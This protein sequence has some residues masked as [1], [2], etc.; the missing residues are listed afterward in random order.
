MTQR[1][2][3]ELDLNT[4]KEVELLF[5]EPVSGEGPYGTY[6]L[7]AVKSDNEEYS[8]FANDDVNEQLKNLSCGDK[9]ILTKLSTQRGNRTF[10][11]IIVETSKVKQPVKESEPEDPIIEDE[12][13]DHLYDIMLSSYRDALK[14]QSELNGLVEVSRVAITLFIARSKGN[15]YNNH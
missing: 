8:F 7:Y 2:K 15:G 13:T 6:H 11:K 1:K 3:L 14:I 5:D 10:S 4:S 9:A 12:Y